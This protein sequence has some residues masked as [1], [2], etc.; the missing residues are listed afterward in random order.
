MIIYP[1]PVHPVHPSTHPLPTRPASGWKGY[2]WG[3]GCGWGHSAAGMRHPWDLC[4]NFHSKS[5]LLDGFSN[6]PN[7]S[8]FL[9]LPSGKQTVCY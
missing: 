2:G 7:I 1:D 8:I 3:K 6:A 9:G 5:S 4:W